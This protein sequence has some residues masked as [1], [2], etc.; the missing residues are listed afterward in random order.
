MLMTLA[1]GTLLLATPDER[2]FLT[3]ISSAEDFSKKLDT[4]LSNAKKTMERMLSAKGKRTI[5][6]TLKPYDE[7]LVELDAAG[8]QA[9]L[10]ENIHPDTVVSL[11]EQRDEQ[12]QNF[13]NN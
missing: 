6:N 10:M 3:G 4:H 11:N 5:E 13:D 12:D 9:S 1:L 8:A 7:I 2:P